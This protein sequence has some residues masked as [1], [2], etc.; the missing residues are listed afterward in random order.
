MEMTFC[1]H[2]G[3]KLGVQQNEFNICFSCKKI[4]DDRRELETE[5]ILA[6]AQRCVDN[7]FENAYTLLMCIMDYVPTDYR[8]YDL[9]SKCYRDGIGVE[10]DF[11]KSEMYYS[12]AAQYGN[13]DYEVEY[14]R[15][16]VYSGRRESL[17]WIKKACEDGKHAAIRTVAKAYAEN[18]ILDEVKDSYRAIIEEEIEK[19]NGYAMAIRAIDLM[20]NYDESQQPRIEALLKEG[21][22]LGN[23]EACDLYAELVYN[24]LLNGEL[25]EEEKDN[26]LE[27]AIIWAK[28]AAL[29]GNLYTLRR[30]ADDI[31]DGNGVAQDFEKAV[32]LYV[33]AKDFGDDTVENEL[34]K[35][36]ADNATDEDSKRKAFNTC[37]KNLRN[38]VYV[39]WMYA[40]AKDYMLGDNPDGNSK[41]NYVHLLTDLSSTIDHA[42]VDLYRIYAGRS[43]KVTAMKDI[44]MAMKYLNA[45][46]DNG[47]DLAKYYMADVYRNGNSLVMKDQKKAFKLYSEL[48]PDHSK[49]VAY[50]IASMMATAEGTERNIPKC[51]EILQKIV[52]DEADREEHSKEYV[53]AEIKLKQLKNITV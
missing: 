29:R 11:E 22:L 46:L 5:A 9:L 7:N 3:I 28:A 19:S 16:L 25:P 6:E 49:T 31:K 21:A 26:G 2:C 39:P 30:I 27:N 44:G 14:V 4:L 33:F 15:Y 17:D 1:R 12:K 45:A 51:K 42:S 50:E 38:G 18:K 40:Y 23:V 8:V 32:D 34:A 35:L 41:A 52:D 48:G 37:M 13:D 10:K 24:K 47:F 43:S 53:Q 20:T 36:Y